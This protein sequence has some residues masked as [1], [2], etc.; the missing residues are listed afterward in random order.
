M[1]LEATNVGKRNVAFP[2][3]VEIVVHVLKG[4]EG[5]MKVTLILPT[6][7]TSIVIVFKL[8]ITIVISLGID[9]SD[10]LTIV[11]ECTI[12]KFYYSDLRTII[13][14]NGAAF[15]DSIVDVG[16]KTS[17]E[18]FSDILKTIFYSSWVA[19]EKR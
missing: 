6:D 15:D 17:W 9:F 11:D 7:N 12:Q 16:K 19:I 5:V 18:L 2:L 10:I 3:L 8:R 4:V 14:I 13:A 1:K